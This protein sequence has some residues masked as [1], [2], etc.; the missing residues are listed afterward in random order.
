M[1]KTVG[2]HLDQPFPVPG[3]SCFFPWIVLET[4]LASF[5]SSNS[6]RER[7]RW[8]GVRK[9]LALSVLNTGGKC[10]DISSVYVTHAH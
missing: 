3:F 9:L 1:P 7:K 5:V 4:H 10:R 2:P 6:I 8:D